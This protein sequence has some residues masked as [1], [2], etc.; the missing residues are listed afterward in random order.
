MKSL[1]KHT[2]ATL[3]LAGLMSAAHAQDPLAAGA[4]SVEINQKIMQEVFASIPQDKMGDANYVIDKMIEKMEENLPA[5][6]EAGQ[7]DCVALYGEAKAEACA[8]VQDKTNY[9]EIFDIMKKQATNPQS[10]MSEL[11]NIAK[12]GEETSLACG[13]TA[14]DIALAQK[15]AQEIMQ[16]AA[17]VK[18]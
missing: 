12:K 3:A 9:N 1:L 16:Q 8:C 5:L 7:K 17:P 10:D 14:E 2:F 4:A 13:F 11:E 18:Q 15:K 6:K